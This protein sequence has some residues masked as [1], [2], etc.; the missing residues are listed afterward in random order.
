MKSE[1]AKPCAP[2]LKDWNTEVHLQSFCILVYFCCVEVNELPNRSRDQLRLNDSPLFLCYVLFIS[3]AANPR[4]E[5]GSVCPSLSSDISIL[6]CKLFQVYR[7]CD[8]CPID[9]C[10]D[11]QLIQ[12]V[13]RREESKTNVN[14]LQTF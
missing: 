2:P 11:F 5:P 6:H 4:S 8:L 7:L 3:P 13:K 9:S 1:N 12:K 10:Q 14:S